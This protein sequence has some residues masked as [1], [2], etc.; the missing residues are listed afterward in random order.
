MTPNLDYKIATP[1]QIAADLGK[2]LAR[3]RLSRNITQQNLA[4]RAGLSDRTLK[5]IEGGEGASLDTLIRL[6][7]A[8]GLHEHLATLL[9]DPG[10]QP[11]EKVERR[12]RE[13]QRARPRPEPKTPWR[14]DEK[15]TP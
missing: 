1:E 6:M 14:W 5:R 4:Q 11:M 2:T 15:E 9:P 8:L 13:R 3:I 10:L 12:G 7:Q